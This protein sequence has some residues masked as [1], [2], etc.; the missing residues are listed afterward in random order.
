MTASGSTRGLVKAKVCE[1]L[2]EFI[3]RHRRQRWLDEEHAGAA[4]NVHGL[5]PTAYLCSGYPGSCLY[6]DDAFGATGGNAVCTS[7]SRYAVLC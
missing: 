2:Q 1:A 6:A 5:L 3:S 4:M 7:Q